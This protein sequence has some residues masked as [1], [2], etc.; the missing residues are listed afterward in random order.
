L[1]TLVFGVLPSLCFFCNAGYLPP[2]RLPRRKTFA[3][4]RLSLLFHDC[5]SRPCLQNEF[6]AQLWKVMACPLLL[7]RLFS[8]TTRAIALFPKSESY[9]L[10]NDSAIRMFCFSPTVL[11][12]VPYYSQ[13]FF[14]CFPSNYCRNLASH[15][16][17]LFES[18][19][20]FVVLDIA[21]FI[22]HV[23]SC[24]GTGCK[25]DTALSYSSSLSL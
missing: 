1:V 24:S 17:F 20:L 13:S 2:G 16:V 5:V 14:S 9:L 23:I 7:C 10:P 4:W 3:R 22:F 25:F 11:F 18:F 19:L 12:E 15:R 8:L 21:S 6:F